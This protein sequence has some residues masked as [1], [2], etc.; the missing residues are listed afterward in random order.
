MIKCSCGTES[1]HYHLGKHLCKYCY[2]IARG[3]P[4]SDAWF[5]VWKEY[6]CLHPVIVVKWKEQ[7]ADLKNLLE[8]EGER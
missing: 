7:D 3:K 5:F 6:Q 8:G 2:W 1:S 4:V